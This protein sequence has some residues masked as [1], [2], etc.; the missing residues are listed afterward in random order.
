[1]MDIKK[2]GFFPAVLT[3]TLVLSGTFWGMDNAYSSGTMVDAARSDD[4]AQLQQLIRSGADVNIPAPDG[5][6]PLLWAVY[7]SSSELVQLLL[8][9]DADPN[10]PNKLGITPLLQASRYGDASMISMLISSGAKLVHSGLGVESP[11]MAAARSG[12]TGA[13][14]ALLEAGSNPN[15]SE[16][17]DDQTALM[18]AAAEGHL[19]VVKIL[20]DA[21]ADP[22]MQSPGIRTDKTQKRRFSVRRFCSPCTGPRATA[23]KQ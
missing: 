21:G 12:N 15:A 1:M 5:T 18:W 11:L 3:V 2:K 23:T 6:T 7:N 19:D 22:N 9:A 13:V 10:I 17:V 16:P 14:K 4:Q 8:D 20:L